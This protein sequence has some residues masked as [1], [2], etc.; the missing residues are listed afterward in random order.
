MDQC[1]IH[2]VSATMWR[3]RRAKQQ[4]T[5]QKDKERIEELQRRISEF[6][7]QVWSWESWWAS[8]RGPMTTVDVV[9]RELSSHH[10]VQ[11]KEVGGWRVQARVNI[12]DSDGFSYSRWENLGSGSSIA[13]EEEAEEAAEQEPRDEGLAGLAEEDGIDLPYC[14]KTG[15]CLSGAEQVISGGIEQS[16]CAFFEEEVSEEE[17]SEE[18]VSEEEVSEEEVS[19]EEEEGEKEEGEEEEREEGT[20][21]A[22]LDDKAQKEEENAGQRNRDSCLE[23]VIKTQCCGSKN[24]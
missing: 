5:K 10:D 21:S 6:E 11:E 3:V 1:R 18:E 4:E 17:I 23:F 7:W 22:L 14:C 12:T 19:E 15:M 24:A 8:K 20:K 13:E 9:L 16:D 2:I